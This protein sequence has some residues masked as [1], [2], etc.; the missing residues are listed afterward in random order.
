MP[1]EPALAAQP[2]PLDVRRRP[3]PTS[4]LD[5]RWSPSTAS[6]SSTG[7]AR[8]SGCGADD[9]PARLRAVGR[10]LLPTAERLAGEFHTLV[11]DLPG[12]GRSGKPREPLDVPELAHAAAAFLDDRG[13]DRVTLVGNSMGCAVICEFAHHYPERLERAVLVAP[14]G[15]LHNQPLHRASGS[16]PV[17]ASG[18]PCSS[19]GGRPRLPEVR[20]AQHG[21]D[22]PGADPL[23][24]ARPPAGAAGSPRS[25]WSAVPTP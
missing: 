2:A 22:V 4:A 23:P 1:D 13:I 11:P 21:A 12:F 20:R 10:Y 15:G 9:A 25:S 3:A 8:P 6:R 19:A 5:S 14:A 7:V 16:W 18:N 24:G 17:T